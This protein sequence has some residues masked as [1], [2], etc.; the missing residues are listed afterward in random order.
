MHFC[1]IQTLKVDQNCNRME[2]KFLIPQH[3]DAK[4]LPG[5]PFC[6]LA[7]PPQLSVVCKSAAAWTFV[8][9]SVIAGTSATFCPEHPK[10]KADMRTFLSAPKNRKSFSSIYI[11]RLGIVSTCSHTKRACQWQQRMWLCCRFGRVTSHVEGPWRST[12][13]DMLIGSKAARLLAPPSSL[14]E[15]P[16]PIN[17]S[18]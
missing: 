18:G 7:A 17:N 11:Y 12:K 5:N 10:A 14:R 9:Q 16:N 2:W 6:P 3:W 1:N 13:I 4:A 8:K 15:E